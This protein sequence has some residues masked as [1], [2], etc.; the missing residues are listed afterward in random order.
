MNKPTIVVNPPNLLKN[1]IEK[2]FIKEKK[3]YAL[4]QLSSNKNSGLKSRRKRK[5]SRSESKKKR[6]SQSKSKRKRKSKK[7]KSLIPKGINKDT[8][9]VLG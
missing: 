6:K 1:Q 4:S 8:L 5:S 9:K 2:R 3:Y 7:K